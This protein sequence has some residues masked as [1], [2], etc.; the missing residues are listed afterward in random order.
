MAHGRSF[1]KTHQQDASTPWPVPGAGACLHVRGLR[2]LWP[3]I[4]SVT[5]SFYDWNGL[6]NKDGDFT[7]T[8]VGHGQLCR[9]LR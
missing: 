7:G 8:F 3:I 9:T 6:Y 5:L 1:W 4:Q 2:V